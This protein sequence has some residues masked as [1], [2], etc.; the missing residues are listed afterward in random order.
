MTVEE[1][2]R[3]EVKSTLFSI[4]TWGMGMLAAITYI[5]GM[6]LQTITSQEEETKCGAEKKELFSAK[7]TIL[8]V[9][10]GLKMS[11]Q[12]AFAHGDVQYVLHDS[13]RACKC[14]CVCDRA[15]PRSSTLFTVFALSDI[16]N[17]FLCEALSKNHRKSSHDIYRC[18]C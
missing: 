14:T 18:S 8:L 10:S 5:K 16:M 4:L 17:H 6:L 7:F 9:I 12:D 2:Q 15:S 3:Q 13:A 11:A 1:F